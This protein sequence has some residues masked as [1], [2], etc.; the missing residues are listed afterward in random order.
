MASEAMRALIERRKPKGPT[1][2]A[3]ARKKRRDEAVAETVRALVEARDGHCKYGFDVHPANR[4]RCGADSQ[5]AHFGERKRFKTRGMDPTYRHAT[6]HSLMLCGPHHDA[7]DKGLLAI[8]LVTE[9][10]CDGPLEYR[11]TRN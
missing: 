7:Y 4:S 9:A 8:T 10:G 5:W 1:A 2:R 11:E 3:R 6:T